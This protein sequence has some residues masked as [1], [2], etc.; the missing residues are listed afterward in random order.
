MA[1]KHPHLHPGLFGTASGSEQLRFPSLDYSPFRGFPG[2]LP[3]HAPPSFPG[4]GSHLAAA[5]AA[6]AAAASTGAPGA[7]RNHVGNGVPGSNL[8]STHHSSSNR[9][10]L[11]GK[12]DSQNDVTTCQ[13][14]FYIFI[15]GNILVIMS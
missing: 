5:A 6:A 1:Q 8:P 11:D 12:T 4:F 14:K 9:G 7:G 13:S 3:P 15:Y 10:N 2:A